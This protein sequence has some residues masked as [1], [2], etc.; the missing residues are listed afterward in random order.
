[1]ASALLPREKRRGACAVYAF[2]RTADDLVDATSDCDGRD[3]RDGRDAP[4]AP[5]RLQSYRLAVD[6]ALRRGNEWDE[7]SPDPVLRELAW[8]VRRFAVPAT[9]IHELLDGVSRDLVPVRYPTWNALAS[10]AEGVASSV[11]EMCAAVF[12]VPHGEAE[13]R[14]AIRYARTLG[15]AMQLTNIL[16]DVGEDARRGRCYLPEHDLAAFGF[17]TEDVLTGRVRMRPE[18]W[19]ALLRF[20]IARARALYHDA[21]PGIEL[22]HPD[23]RR[24][25]LACATGYAAILAV[26]E[27]RDFDC[28]T[29]RAVV[30]RSVLLGVMARAWLGRPR[31]ARC[32]DVARG[33]EW[34]APEALRRQ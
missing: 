33:H 20:E 17:T 13:R 24:C 1:M 9:A 6:D 12:G 2:C 26:L 18:A 14:R 8:A 31:L 22:L 7:P 16:R 15:V 10:Y 21:L 30:P 34:L 3:G 23:A 32:G 5:A 4:G 19:R 25:A 29:R 11:G 27:R 28:L